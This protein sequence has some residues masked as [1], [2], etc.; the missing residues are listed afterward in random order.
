MGF[1]VKHMG[2]VHVRRL[3]CS[4]CRKGSCSKTGREGVSTACRAITVRTTAM[5][6]VPEVSWWGRFGCTHPLCS[7]CRHSPLPFGCPHPPSPFSLSLLFF[8]FSCS[9]ALQVWRRESVGVDGVMWQQISLLSVK[10]CAKCNF[11]VKYVW[12]PDVMRHL[13]AAV[14]GLMFEHNQKAEI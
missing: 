1:F 3:V 5:R 6:T 12:S 9:F 8:S 14:S 4:L 2:L 13:N 7:V 10:S 11:L